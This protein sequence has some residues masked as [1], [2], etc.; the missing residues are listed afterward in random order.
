M[1]LESR[2]FVAVILNMYAVFFVSV[3][4][5]DAGIVKREDDVSLE[6]LR[7]LVQQQG[8]AIQALQ[9]SATASEA[10]I[11]SLTSETSAVKSQLEATSKA[12]L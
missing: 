8:S 1:A 6:A 12:G 2:S 7:T 4:P 5:A 10:K 3:S 9:A 11:S